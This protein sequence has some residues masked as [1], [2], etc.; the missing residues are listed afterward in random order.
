MAPLGA[1]TE[2]PGSVPIAPRPEL[3]GVRLPA[4]DTTVCS[5]PV[6]VA[7]R[8]D[9]GGWWNQ[10]HK[11]VIVTAGTRSVSEILVHSHQVQDTAGPL[12][13]GH[14]WKLVSLVLFKAARR[15]HQAPVWLLHL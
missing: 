6:E 8:L 7:P 15:G 1:P 10:H 3:P 9:F 14:L 5:P 12:H 11:T 2:L 4:V 13:T